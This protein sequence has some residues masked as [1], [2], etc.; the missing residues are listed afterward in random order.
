MHTDS[1]RKVESMES[2]Q[3]LAIAA[4]MSMFKDFNRWEE[5]QEEIVK[6]PGGW[7]TWVVEEE[8]QK[9]WQ[10]QQIKKKKD[11]FKNVHRQ[12][13]SMQTCYCRRLTARPMVLKVKET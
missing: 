10:K 3:T 11:R 5:V 7:K 13:V 6:M 9:A 2:L 12:L 1:I 8:M 4:L